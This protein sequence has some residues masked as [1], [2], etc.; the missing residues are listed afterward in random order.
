MGMLACSPLRMYHVRPVGGA[1]IR[2]TNAHISLYR[3]EGGYLQKRVLGTS[4]DH[5]YAIVI[6]DDD[7]DLCYAVR[8]H[9]SKYRTG[10]PTGTGRESCVHHNYP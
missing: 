10:V 3:L 6:P 5:C 9:S 2:A 7:L 4:G 1:E 8:V